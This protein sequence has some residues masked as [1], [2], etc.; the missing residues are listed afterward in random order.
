MRAPLFLIS[1]ALSSAACSD[2]ADYADKAGIEET[3]AASVQASTSPAA[4]AYSV[5]QETERF[6]F[7]YAWPAAAA[8][9]PALAAYLAKKADAMLAEVR[10]E[11][12]EEW[13]AAKG[14][15][16]VSRQHSASEE[17]K[18][19]ADLPRFLSLSGHMATYSGGAHGL[20]GMESL[21]WDREKRRA[22]RGIELFNSP[23]S[24]EQGLGQRLCDRLNA[25][26]EKRR[27][28]KIEEGSEEMFDKCPG[29]DEADVLVGSSNGKTFDRITVYFG[30]YV[31]GSYAEGDYELDF[32]VTASILDAVKPEFASAFSVRS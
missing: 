24:L 5:E 29:L 20:Y 10:G 8:A 27:G 30:P 2:A 14:E 11:A 3:P 9:E 16:W 7:A 28:T 26:R 25:A 6:Q 15:D 31:A 19:V 1:L 23:V 21:V 32:N 13:D 18:V 17:W 22:M 12:D 4:E